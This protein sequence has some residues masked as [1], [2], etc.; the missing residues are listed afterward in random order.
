MGN[1]QS[2]LFLLPF[3]CK[4]GYIKPLS[5]LP[6]CLLKLGWR[7]TSDLKQ[8]T[9]GL[10]LKRLWLKDNLMLIDCFISKLH[11][12]IGWFS[13]WNIME[14]KK[15]ICPSLHVSWIFREE[16][17]LLLEKELTNINGKIYGFELHLKGYILFPC[18][19]G[20]K[21]TIKTF[22]EIVQRTS[23]LASIWINYC[24]TTKSSR[25]LRRCNIDKRAK[26]EEGQLK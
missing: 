20:Q 24:V 11:I 16:K 4:I 25:L 5:H 7:D 21:H 18:N 15:R 12:I 1:R 6:Y 17:L 10:K 14:M 9:W 8:N 23:S 2:W 13:W 22:S 26:A 3:I 19:I